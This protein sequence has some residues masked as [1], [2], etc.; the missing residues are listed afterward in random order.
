MRF[1]SGWKAH[2]DGRSRRREPKVEALWTVG[3][4]SSRVV[5]IVYAKLIQHVA[6]RRRRRNDGF[7]ET[8]TAQREWAGRNVSRSDCLCRDDVI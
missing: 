8:A 3:L 4:P 5:V 6:M 2:C 1:D 7:A